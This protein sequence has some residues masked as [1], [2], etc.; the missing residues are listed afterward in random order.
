MVKQFSPQSDLY[1]VV[2]SC[3]EAAW[4]NRLWQ[5]ALSQICE[6]LGSP[7]AT[8][9][10]SDRITG[11]LLGFQSAGL[12]PQSIADYT[13][14]FHT[15]NPR[16]PHLQQSKQGDVLY[17]SMVMS[18]KQ[19]DNDEF[20]NDLLKPYGLRYFMASSL[21]STSEQ[22]VLL[23]PHRTIKQGH[24]T[25]TDVKSIRTIS[26]Y[27]TQAYQLSQRI[28]SL[29]DTLH[30]YMQSLHMLDVGVLILSASATIHFVNR[31][32]ERLLKSN[33]E[34]SL[35]QR[36]LR[37]AKSG[38]RNQFSVSLANVL[39]NR[40]HTP[41]DPILI[42]G[43]VPNQSLMIN[44]SPLYAGERIRDALQVAK[45][46]RY[47][48]VMLKNSVSRESLPLT[49]LSDCFNLTPKECELAAGLIAG[50]TFSQ[51][52]DQNRVSNNTIRTHYANLRTKLG[53]RNQADVLRSLMPF[54]A[55]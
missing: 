10:S 31:K 54:I 17:D 15:I 48:L 40:I 29:R 1:N 49:L 55:A 9:E 14:Y 36:G 4:D 11:N 33:S 34:V 25:R 50:Q 39:N 13:N 8:L 27:V 32:A 19:M 18:E 23:A 21:I 2:S 3:Y 7:C 52:A 43:D 45:N 51:I 42:K 46:K 44:V 53:A 24:A 38:V 12:D 26:R 16:H 28:G 41:S 47:A 37:F 35:G 6:H 20:Y 30:S 22:L 5:S